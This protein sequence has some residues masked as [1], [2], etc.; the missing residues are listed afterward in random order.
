MCE[1]GNTLKGKAPGLAAFLAGC[2]ILIWLDQ[3]TKRWL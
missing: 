1:T 2:G 3:W